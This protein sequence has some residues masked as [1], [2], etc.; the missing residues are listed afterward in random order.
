MPLPDLRDWEPTRD[1]L[2]H[3][4]R[5]LGALQFGSSQEQAF[6]LHHSLKLNAVGLATERLPFGQLTLDLGWV[7]GLLHVKIAGIEDEHSFALDGHNLKTLMAAVAGAITGHG[8]VIDYDPADFA[9]EEAFHI[10]TAQISAYGQ[11]LN[12]MFTAFARARA[13]LAGYFSPLVIWP[14]AF[15]M[16]FMWF[17]D[18]Q[19]LDPA[20][21]PHL[22]FGF[23]PGNRPIPRPFVYVQGKSAAGLLDDVVSLPDNVI[24]EQVGF[25]GVR[26]DYDTFRRQSDTVAFVET[27]LLE[28]AA[29]LWPYLASE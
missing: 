11:V 27:M 2:H 19:K 22:K 10:E 3:A 17:K 29:R 16:S 1:A 5:V 24:W 4:A 6:D 26:M 12:T 7:P 18:P 25:R 14:R 21:D 23:S 9:D 20:R 13:R 15:D 8:Y 28:I